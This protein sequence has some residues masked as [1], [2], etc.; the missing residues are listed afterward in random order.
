MQQREWDEYYESNE[1]PWTIPD[2]WLV[3]EV[4][5]LPPGRALDL[6]AGE[7][8]DTIWL[9]ERGW[10]VTAVDYA[11]AAISTV[12]QIASG[13]GLNIR[14]VVANILEYQPD[15]NYDLVIMCYMHLPPDERA[16]MLTNATTALAPGG[17][18]LY[19]GLPGFDDSTNGEHSYDT[20]HSHDTEYSEE[21]FATADEIV[22]IVAKLPGLAIERA[23]VLR[24]MIPYPNDP[25]EGEGVIVRARRAAGGFLTESEHRVNSRP[26]ARYW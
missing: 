24:R 19:I 10:E 8:G 2:E 11:P 9:A 1:E 21:L 5:N 14:S 20:E 3:A 12:E 23:E 26:L 18:L 4:E 22:E 13:R 6:G 15:C 16:T 25:Y 7:G 17:T